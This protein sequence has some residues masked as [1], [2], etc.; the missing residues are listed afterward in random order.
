MSYESL[1][2][3]TS[4]N[5]LQNTLTAHSI[6]QTL[7]SMKLCTIVYSQITS[8]PV[9]ELKSLIKYNQTNA[10]VHDETGASI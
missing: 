10:F 9:N 3:I 2:Q 5:V 7:I 8:G 1:N 4:F 6:N